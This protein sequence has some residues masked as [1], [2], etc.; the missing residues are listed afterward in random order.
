MQRLNLYFSLKNK[1]YG[2]KISVIIIPTGRDVKFRTINHHSYYNY[3]FQQSLLLI[4]VQRNSRMKEL[5]RIL[6]S[7]IE[8][9]LYS[10][11]L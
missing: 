7:W 6:D 10:K 11:Y 2:F 8:S 5:F 4:Y 9:T 3:R 1:S